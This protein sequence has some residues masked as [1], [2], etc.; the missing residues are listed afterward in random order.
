MSIL[1]NLKTERMKLTQVSKKLDITVTEASRH[2]Q[3]LS[4]AK[5]ISRDSDGLYL[6]TGLGKLAISQIPNLSFITDHSEY[7]L[8]HDPSTLPYQFL[9]RL[10]ELSECRFDSDT[11]RNVNHSAQMVKDAEEY[12]CVMTYQYPVLTTSIIEQRLDEGLDFRFL[13]PEGVQPP[14]GIR[15]DVFRR[16]SMRSIPRIEARVILTDKE[17]QFG[18]PSTDGRSDY[19]AFISQSEKFRRWSRDLFEHYWG[20]GKKLLL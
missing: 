13:F 9:N 5:L 1:E 10:G 20:T 16:C 12:A 11:G 6:L 4:D 7:F 17:A 15:L 18:V 2:L 3:R 14:E 8:S 19:A